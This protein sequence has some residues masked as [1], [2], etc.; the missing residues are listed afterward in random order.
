MYVTSRMS[1]WATKAPRRV[2]EWGIQAL[3]YA[4]GTLELGLE[5][6][7]DPGPLFGSKDQLASPRDSLVSCPVR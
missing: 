1:Q 6:L 7:Q 3:K 4:A 5:F 2:K